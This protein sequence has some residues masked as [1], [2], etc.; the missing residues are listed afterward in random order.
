[1]IPYHQ[2]GPKV[3]AEIQSYIIQLRGLDKPYLPD[4][5]LVSKLWAYELRKLQY[6]HCNLVDLPSAICF[7]NAIIHPLPL[8]P[9]TP[10]TPGNLV[11]SIQIGFSCDPEEEGTQQ[12]WDLLQQALPLLTKMESF[13]IC[14][15]HYD[16]EGIEAFSELAR[17]FPPSLNLLYFKPT[18]EE[19]YYVCSTTNTYLVLP[20]LTQAQV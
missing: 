18:E 17:Y 13:T 14:Y 12:L 11:R 19:E 9:Q 5:Y 20:L 10:L 6:K 15:S 8:L 7:L 3:P 16:P 1:M 4:I 2:I